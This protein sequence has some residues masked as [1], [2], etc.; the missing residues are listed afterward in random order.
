M[1]DVWQVASYSGENLVTRQRNDKLREAKST[2]SVNSIVAYRVKVKYRE[3]RLCTFLIKDMTFANL[4]HL[5][6]SNIRVR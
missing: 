3:E 1:C 2:F 5:P 4:A 6:S